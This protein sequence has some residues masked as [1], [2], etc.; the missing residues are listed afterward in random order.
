MKLSTSCFAVSALLL[1]GLFNVAA[2]DSISFLAF[3]DG[4]Y[5]PDYP[6]TKHIKKPKNK[7]QFIAAERADWL[8][9]HRPIEEFNHAPIYVYPGTEIATEETGAAAV[10]KAMAT[11]CERKACEFGIQLGDNIYPDGA[12]ANDGKDD[13]KRMNDLILGP[14]KPLFKNNKELVVYSAL[15]N[16]DWKTSRKGVKLQTQWMANQPNF[17]MDKRGYYSYRV[18]ETGNDVEF[19]VL[20]TNMLLSGQHYYE[21]PLAKD[22]SEQ[23]LAT[24]L[25]HGHAEVEDIEVHESPVNGEDHKQL[26]WLAKGLKTS[27]A[28]W[29]IVYGHH[30]LWSIGGTKYDEGHVLRRLILPELCQYADTYIAGHEHDLELLTDDCSRVMPGNSKPKL[31]LIISGA[32]SKMRGTHTPFAQ[33][34]ENRYP[35]YDLIWTKSF[36]WGF[37]HIELDNRGDSLNVSFYTTP[38]DKSG[39]VIPEASFSFKHRSE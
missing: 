11:L 24:A 33:Q 29:K 16:H 23:G 12:D 34:Q 6:K 36:I 1:S 13:Q 25:A 32:A 5:H 27:T 39:H 10:G 19:F 9:D 8:E 17:H 7:Q 31:P 21:I 30:I 2:K 15:G 26:A 28:K 37:A 18:G 3:G 22:G 38:H 4:G 20:D 14:L 35:E